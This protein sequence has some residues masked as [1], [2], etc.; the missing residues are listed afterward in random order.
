M[1][2]STEKSATNSETVNVS[3]EAAEAS[4]ETGGEATGRPKPARG[5]AKRSSA[6]KAKRR[7]EL[8]IK[9]VT[10]IS[11]LLIW[12]YLSRVGVISMLS[13]PRPTRLVTAIVGLA[14]QGFP[15]GI[16]VF[17]HLEATVL[18]ILQGYALG[19]AAA[20]PLG[21]MVGR[22]QFLERAV[23]PVVT[24]AR[25]IATLSLLPL[26]IAWFGVGEL[27]RILLITYASFWAVLTNTIQG[28][29]SV[30]PAYIN[31]GKM[32][33]ASRR[34]IFFR[35]ILPATLP[36]IFAGLKVALGL[37]FMV[38]IGVEMIGTIEGLGALIQ[39]SRYY[40]RT[41]IAI[42]GTVLIGAFG[43]IITIILDWLERILL[44]WAGGLEEV[45]R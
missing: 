10:I 13:L 5:R 28:A 12:E 44:P 4:G 26:A 14:T 35:V 25:S 23:N 18:R 27:A 21:L 3:S 15:Q 34:A 33:G 20:I 1:A 30:D 7:S 16:L 40:Y 41:D 6:A 37:S 32:F 2:Q 36:R 19:A 31:V 38:I 9:S 39:Q 29:R 24:F 17:A 22:V 42:A 11:L 45:E 43:L 8:I